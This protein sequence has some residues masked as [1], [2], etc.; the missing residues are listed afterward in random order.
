MPFKDQLG[1]EL[2]ILFTVTAP[3]Q[4]LAGLVQAMAVPS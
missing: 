1:L 4:T 3:E 2:E